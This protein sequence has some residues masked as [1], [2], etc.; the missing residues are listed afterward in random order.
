MS[1]K[2]KAGRKV[3][4]GVA[5]GA[6]VTKLPAGARGKWTA[7]GAARAARDARIATA[8][9]LRGAAVAQQWEAS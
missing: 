3:P 9:H 6:G 5:A 8:A 4:R 1:R 7:A 2:A